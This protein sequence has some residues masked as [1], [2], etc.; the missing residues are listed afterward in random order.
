MLGLWYPHEEPLFSL[1]GCESWNRHL[2][3]FSSVS[4]ARA[5]L[6]FPLYSSELTL[7]LQVHPV[8]RIFCG[9]NANPFTFPPLSRHEIDEAKKH[10]FT[11]YPPWFGHHKVPEGYPILCLLYQHLEENECKEEIGPASISFPRLLI[12]TDQFLLRLSSNCSVKSTR[13]SATTPNM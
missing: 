7:S 12:V 3:L 5:P 13:R 4:E 11:L 8:H 10:L 2:P 6:P 9:K 1:Y